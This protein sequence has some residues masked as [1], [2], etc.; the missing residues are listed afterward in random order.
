M[1]D[2][3]IGCDL[4]LWPSL[5]AKAV[6]ATGLKVQSILIDT[7]Q[8]RIGIGIGIFMDWYF[9]IGIG[10]G[11]IRSGYTYTYT[12]TTKWPPLPGPALTS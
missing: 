6:P 5:R 4:Y 1:F 10:I 7:V 11:I 12:Y 8:Y 3:N 9:S 2:V